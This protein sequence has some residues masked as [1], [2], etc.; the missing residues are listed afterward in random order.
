MR[1]YVGIDV[2]QGQL[3]LASSNSAAVQAF[4]YDEGGLA[5][6]LEHLGSLEPTLVVIEATGGIERRLVAALAQAGIV[7]A[8]VNPRQVRD[9]ARA[10]GEL[11]KTD[12]I[13]ARILALFAERIRPEARPLP[14]ETTQ[15]LDAL[16]T[17][18]RQL[19][20]MRT[21]EQNRLRLAPKAV[22]RTIQAHIRWLDRQL[23]DVDADLDRALR[24]SPLWRAKDQL[25][26]SVPGIGEVVSRTLLA[27]LPELGQLSRREIAKLAG[28]APL[29]RDSGKHRGRRSVW[30]G[31]AAV[32]STLYM[33]SLVASR[34]N[35]VIRS[36]Y[37]HLL[38]RGKPKKVAL[39]ACIRKLLVILNAMLR[40][41][42]PW[43]PGYSH[44]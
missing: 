2:A 42:Q 30:G 5:R 4:A 19:I 24:D 6:L 34:H 21:A 9:F 13:D 37:R 25:L 1:L 26:R 23:R 10:T 43:N 11:A 27:E 14:D 29:A 32:R 44:T 12:R 18:R 39:T 22:Q 16:I 28:V 40:D 17:R 31:R 41:Q 8:V 36:F 3:D 15:L 33:A 7:L 20:E 38:E 35:P